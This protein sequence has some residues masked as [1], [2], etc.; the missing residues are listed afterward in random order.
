MPDFEMEMVTSK[1]SFQRIAIAKSLQKLAPRVYMSST[2]NRDMVPFIQKIQKRWRFFTATLKDGGYAPFDTKKFGYAR[3]CVPVLVSAGCN[4]GKLIP[5]DIALCPFCWSRRVVIRACELLEPYKNDIEHWRWGHVDFEPD[6]RVGIGANVLRTQVGKPEFLKTVKEAQNR[7]PSC[8]GLITY[9]YIWTGEDGEYRGRIKYLGIDCD[10]IEPA[11]TKAKHAP[12]AIGQAFAYP[13]HI[14]PPQSSPE[15]VHASVPWWNELREMNFRA[16]R[17]KGIFYNS[18]KPRVRK[19]K[20]DKFN[21]VYQRL[22][23][24][25]KKLG[26]CEGRKEYE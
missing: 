4:E 21:E 9:T 3:N 15:Q 18:G 13:V 2:K 12:R 19:V 7:L 17:T 20:E 10:V 16:F 23:I 14:V 1:P 6:L 5:C 24:L 25:E 8:E 26:L 11:F 22:E